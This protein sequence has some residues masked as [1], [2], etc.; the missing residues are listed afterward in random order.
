MARD[1]RSG[2]LSE[3]E[4]D[5]VGP[6]VRAGET[7]LDFGA[8]YGLYAAALAKAVGR[9]G[10]VYAFEPIPFTASTLQVVLRLLRAGNVEVVPKAVGE[11]SGTLS[12]SLPI[13]ES[14]APQAGQ[15]H[16]AARRDARPGRERHAR[17]S[18]TE[19]VEC[20][21]VAVDDL[22]LSGDVSFIKADIEGAELFAFRG[23]RELIERSH[24]SV[25]CEIN[26]WFLQGF[27]LT[28]EA[29]VSFFAE[30]G[31][32]LYRYA[33]RRLTEIEEPATVEEDNYLFLHP[34]R[35][36]RFASMLAAT[37]A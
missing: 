2:A 1:I 30:R 13:Q 20:D 26:P 7:A 10:R 19:T 8:N 16:V 31:Y 35:E 25:V 9:R 36:S 18:R 4:L 12:F 15:A 33:D 29:L 6:G 5:L 28:V 11:K 34:D 3:P 17:W 32:R 24:P 23:A 27:G 14:G 37:R 21:V 22:L